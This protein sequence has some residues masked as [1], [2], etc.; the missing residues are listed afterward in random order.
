MG[1]ENVQPIKEVCSM[2][3]LNRVFYST[4]FGKEDSFWNLENLT[5]VGVIADYIIMLVVKKH[6]REIRGRPGQP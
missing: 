3:T 5:Q 1:K 2:S 4:D 6:D